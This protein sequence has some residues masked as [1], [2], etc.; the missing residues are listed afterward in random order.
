MTKS[1]RDALDAGRHERRVLTGTVAV[2]IATL[3]LAPA[4]AS[5]APAFKFDVFISS[6][7]VRGAGP[8][9]DTLTLTLK[10]RN[11]RVVDTKSATTNSSG[12]ISMPTCFKRQIRGLDR[13]RATNGSISRQFAVPDLKIT[14]SRVTDLVA[15]RAPAN[16][17][18]TF[19]GCYYHD[20]SACLDISGSANTAGD[21]TFAKDFSSTDLHGGDW[22]QVQWQSPAGDLVTRGGTAPYVIATVGDPSLRGY[23]VPGRKVTAKL[24]RSGV[25]IATF[26]NTAT[27]DTGYW[28]GKLRRRGGALAALRA[29]DH[30]TGTWAGDGALTIPATSVT[31]NATTD[32][33]S[34][35][36]LPNRPVMAY[37]HRANW[38]SL[39]YGYANADATGH[40]NTDMSNALYPTFDLRHGDIV[41]VHCRSG[42]GDE[43]AFTGTVP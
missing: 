23:T 16:S 6:P 8:A 5:A 10:D 28:S 30:I 39:S 26:T 4:P 25:P 19:R 3:I 35:R 12:A 2:A 14:V 38:S 18:V 42:R 20:Y 29:G 32:H 31:G 21:G 15:G 9:N 27:N 24:S 36:C 34:G 41:E 22:A 33:V 17:M 13:I 40:F 11:G 7:C 1:L 43:V 37:A